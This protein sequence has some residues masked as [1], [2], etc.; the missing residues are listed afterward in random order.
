[1]SCAESLIEIGDDVVDMFDADAEPNRF[2][3][4]ASPELL[5]RR[6]L[7]VG[8]GGRMAGQGL[9]ITQVDQTLDQIQ[10][11]I[12]GLGGFEAPF[13]S[14][15]H[16]RAGMAGQVLSGERIMSA[17]SEARVVYPLDP[18]ILA[19]KLRYFFSVLD[20]TLDPKR[21]RF[22]SLEQEES[23]ER[24][25]DRPGG[26]LVHTPATPNVCG[27]FEMVGIDQVVIGGIRLAEH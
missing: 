22:D 16:Q 18:G 10:R 5:F 15:G 7:P 6:H 1:M 14:E 20:V 9:G 19:Q 24:R 23:A 21:K 13:D 11:V 25:Q 4:D 26:S 27:F 2:G 12:K 3:S 8:S 17:V